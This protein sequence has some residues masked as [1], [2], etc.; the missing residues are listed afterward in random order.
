MGQAREFPPAQ[1]AALA[2]LRTPATIR[3]RCQQIF[4]LAQADRLHHFAYHPH[5]LAAVAEYV[6]RV[7]RVTYPTLDIPWHSRWRHFTVG[8]IDRVAALNARLH[9]A[10]PAERARC[11]FDLVITSVL[12]D[13]GAGEHWQYRE[14]DRAQTYTRSEALAVASFDAF[15]AGVFSSQADSPWQADALGLQGLTETKLAQ[16]FQVTDAN[17]LSGVAGRAALLRTLGDVVQ[18]TPQYFG[19]SHP[20][21][22]HLYDYLATQAQG[23]SLP[24]RSVLRAVLDSLSPIWPARLSIGGVNLG[25]VWHHSQITGTGCT[26][27]LIPFHKLSQWLTYSLLEPL[28]AAGLTVTGL[29]DLTGLAEYRNGG[30]LLDLGLIT[31][32][33]ETILRRRHLPESELIVE[34]RALTVSLLD[35]VA[36]R[37]RALLGVSAQHYPLAKVLEGG[38]WRAG[39]QIARALRADGRPPLQIVSDGTVF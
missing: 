19:G 35:C 22:G 11:H 21:L 38:T 39:R 20:R 15:L 3:A 18:H 24:A 27:G 32:R 30:L 14:A 1:R 29:D 26:A 2:Y 37:V 28:S 10:S 25:D 5:R 7:T 23:G 31:P 17:P 34:W 36:E 12:L 8:G 4:E 33:D 13:A 16:A 9:T 6:T